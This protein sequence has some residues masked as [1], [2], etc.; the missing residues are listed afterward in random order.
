VNFQPAFDVVTAGYQGWSYVRGGIFASVGALAL[1][2]LSLAIQSKPRRMTAFS[3]LMIAVAILGFCWSA[4]AFND[5][6]K[7]YRELRAALLAGQC[8][9]TTGVVEDFSPVHPG[10]IYLESFSVNGRRFEYSDFLESPGFHQTKKHGGP[11]S[12]GLKV[13]IHHKNGVIARL[14]LVQ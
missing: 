2:S 11:I 9:V 14:E 6:Y 13:R 3:W 7:P 8:E 1:L 10:A 4:L 12:P 5:T